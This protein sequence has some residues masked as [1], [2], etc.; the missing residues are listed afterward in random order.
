METGD[1]PSGHEAQAKGAPGTVCQT[2]TGDNFTYIIENL[3]MPVIPQH[4]LLDS[5]KKIKYPEETPEIWESM[6]LDTHRI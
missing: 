2:I 1:Y 5:G 3:K 4:M 6:L